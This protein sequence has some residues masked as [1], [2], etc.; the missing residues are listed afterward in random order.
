MHDVG[1]IIVPIEILEKPGKLTAEE[2]EI[3]KKHADHGRQ[4]LEKSPGEL[5]QL[6]SVIAYQHHDRW[7]GTGYHGIKG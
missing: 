2:Y 6:A 3:V 1:K 7:D 5:F 4:I